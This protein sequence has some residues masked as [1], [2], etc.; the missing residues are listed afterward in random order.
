[1][2]PAIPSAW[3]DGAELALLFDFVDAGQPTNVGKTEI[4]AEDLTDTEGVPLS[5]IVAP[6]PEAVTAVLGGAAIAE[7]TNLAGLL[8]QEFLLVD[9]VQVGA[10]VDGRIRFFA[11]G[12]ASFEVLSQE[13][14][15]ATKLKL[16]VT[17]YGNV[18]E[19]TRGESVFGEVLGT[20]NGRIPNQRFKLKKKPLTYLPLASTTG[21]S[22]MTSTLQIRVDGVL[23]SQVQT[24][25]GT[26]AEDRVYT[27]RHDDEQNTFVTFGDGIRGARLP[28]GVKNIV[29]SY[30]FGAGAAAPPAGS[31]KQLAGAV[32]GL[33]GVRSPIAASPG[34]APDDPEQLRT[35][36]PRTALLFGRAVSTTDF[37]ALTRE[38]PG[39]VQAK[40]EWLWI[41]AQMQ[42]GV[43]VQY[44]GTVNAET[45]SEA[46][47]A[48]ADPTVP[49]AV[50]QAVGI[51]TTVSIGVEVDERYVKETVASSVLATLT[52]PGT[53]VLSLERARIGGTFWPSALYEA[54]AQVAGVI[55][56][57]GLS[58]T[59]TGGPVISISGGTC[60][61]TGKY[62]D[63]SAPNSVT[64]S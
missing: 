6:P 45:I 20:G 33:R 30:R 44:I 40:A 36:A 55:A 43:V 25:F 62:L 7:N 54:V 15:P 8:E 18:L 9:P 21:D 5:G 10:A 41:D 52:A 31:I 34:K 1:M 16:P 3:D 26:G 51:P 29:A 24:F 60:I 14:L 19:T 42:A 58:F 57:S 32:K 47:G 64:V 38:Q 28:S 50:T 17:V 56:V 11:D 63:F 12:R 49:I 13:Q 4:G 48:Q 46:L 39:V 61:E 53:G 2:L 37:E 35:N 59:T 27:A 23:W 22:I